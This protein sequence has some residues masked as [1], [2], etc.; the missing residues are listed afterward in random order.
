MYFI[1]I[2]I[3]REYSSFG[4]GY[5]LAKMS[6]RFTCLITINRGGRNA[7]DGVLNERSIK[8]VS[9]NIVRIWI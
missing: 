3:V 6:P 4:K 8:C 9:K 1:T 7:K 5:N 2:Y